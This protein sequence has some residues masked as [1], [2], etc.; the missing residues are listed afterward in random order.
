[1]IVVEVCGMVGKISG[2]MGVLEIEDGAVV[3][4]SWPLPSGPLPVH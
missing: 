1:M 3:G 2:R 4:V